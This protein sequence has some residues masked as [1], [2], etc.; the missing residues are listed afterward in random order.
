MADPVFDPNVFD[1]NV[2]FAPNVFEP[3]IHATMLVSIAPL[4]TSVSIAVILTAGAS[5]AIISSV[6]VS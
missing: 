2:F 4:T 5:I 6:P 3:R 1:P